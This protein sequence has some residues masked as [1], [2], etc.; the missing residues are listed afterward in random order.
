V[1]VCPRPLHAYR[2]THRLGEKSSIAR[3]IFVA[4]AAVAAGAFEVNAMHILDRK[5]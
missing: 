2:A 5:G 1:L 4:V 3:R